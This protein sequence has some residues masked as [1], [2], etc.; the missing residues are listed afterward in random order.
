MANVAD[1]EAVPIQHPEFQPEESRADPDQTF[2]SPVAPSHEA[3]SFT[4]TQDGE[5]ADGRVDA[6]APSD[7]QAAERAAEEA[8]ATAKEA[9][10][11]AERAR[12]NAAAEAQKRADAVEAS[13]PRWETVFE[14]MYDR[15]ERL[16]L[17]GGYLLRSTWRHLRAGSVGGDPL[18]GSSVTFVPGDAPPLT[19]AA[20]MTLSAEDLK[21]GVEPAG[22]TLADVHPIRQLA[23]ASE[24][25][26][27]LPDGR[28]KVLK[29]RAPETVGM[30]RDA[31]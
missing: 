17:S 15:T 3:D 13:K 20:V 1:D 4:H 19:D 31:V 23:T 7:V 27:T 30:V 14:T 5:P 29:S 22:A 24:V 9:Q 12:E 2:G 6:S 10:A 16:V 21:S 28:V 25:V 18:T 11:N 8:A 26:L